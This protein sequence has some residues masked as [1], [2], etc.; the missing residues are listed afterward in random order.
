MSTSTDTRVAA[1]ALQQA[2]DALARYDRG[3]GRGALQPIDDAVAAAT[4]DAAP[5][6]DLEQR[7]AAILRGPAPAVA[8]EYACEKL[9]W[10]GGPAAV[11]ALAGLLSNPDLA[12]TATHAL[13]VMTCAEA[14]VA[15]RDNLARL[16]GLALAGVITA[17]GTR[18]D[19]ASAGKLAALLAHPDARVASAA[20]G[21]LGEIG[22]P[23]AGKALREFLP[24]A[25]P[26]IRPA[27][28]DACLVCA[29]RLKA[30]GE[31]GA[32]RVLLD[33]LLATAPPPHVRAAALRINA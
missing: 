4:K 27:L 30:A 16:S 15:L 31:A 7:L 24:K 9:A 20:A 3:S 29:E 5:R 22:S 25:P 18:R 12:H 23:A 2:F 33:A 11:P 19:A 1:A 32:A 10:I 28:G 6:R 8:K 17:L 14:A 21:A 13:Q 26:A